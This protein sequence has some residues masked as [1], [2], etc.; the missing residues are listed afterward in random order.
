M[1]ADMTTTSRLTEPKNKDILISGASVAGPALAYWLR[2]HGFNP[3]VVERAPTLRDGGYAVDF[4]G[5]AHLTVLERMGILADVR[6]ARTR[7]GAMSYVDSAGRKLASMPAD[8]FAGDVEILR[9]DLARIL[10]EAT[11]EHTEYVFG[12]SIASMTE[13]ADGV[14]VTFERGAPRRF[15]LVVGADGLHSNVRSLAFGPES[16]YVKELGLYCAIFTTAN[17][18]GL[19]Y[20]GHA[21]ST[22]GKLTSVYSARHNTEAKAMFYFG[23]PPLSYDRR[24]GEQQKKILA[25]AFAGIGWETPRLLKSMWDAPDFYFDSVSQVHMDR[26]SQGRAVLLGDAA[27]C[28]SPLSGMG[29][30]L[31]MVGAYVLAGELASAGGNHRVGFARYEE[32]MRDYATGCQKS[33][34][35]VSR[36]M[37]P[38]IRFMA[39]FLNQH[40]RLLPYLPGKGLMA[41]SA[42]RTASAIALKS[43]GL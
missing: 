40:Y 8:L 29:T 18:L 5:E 32:A 1:L 9:G 23:S 35:G 38:E 6:R 42:R 30:G 22:P 27:C 24:D 15:D 36:W 34:E 37:V 25:E 17:H 39:W 21:Y 12:D 19:E 7:M 41:K 10:H 4:R 2:R 28:P 20:S 31:A 43:Y 11:R 26:W 33:G 14:T 3:T 16:R 13:D